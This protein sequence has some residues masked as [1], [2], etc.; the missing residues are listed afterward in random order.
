MSWTL[1]ALR[2]LSTLVGRQ[3]FRKSFRP[4]LEH[5]EARLAPANV[6]VLSGHYDAFLSGG[7]TQETALTP[8]T[9]NA[10]NFGNLFNYTVDGYTYAQPLYVPNLTLPGGTH[11]A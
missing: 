11:N 2:R 8:A 1:A 10:T 3:P 4:M 9:V 5:L 7:N 6:P